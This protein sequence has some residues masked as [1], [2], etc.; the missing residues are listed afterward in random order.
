MDIFSAKEA[1]RISIIKDSP[2]NN[3]IIAVEKQNFFETFKW[4]PHLFNCTLI[5]AGGAPSRAVTRRFILEL[6]NLG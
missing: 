3:I 6:K 4:I 5:T 1:G 2:F